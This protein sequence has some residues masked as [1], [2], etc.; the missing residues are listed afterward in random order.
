MPTKRIAGRGEALLSE[1]ARARVVA[2]LVATYGASLTLLTAVPAAVAALD[3]QFALAATLA[4]A[5][6]PPTVAF[7]IARRRPMSDR[8][9]RI[10]ALAAVVLAFVLGALLVAAGFAALGLSP[11]FAFFEAVSAITTTGLSVV[12][13]PEAWPWSAHFLR[14]WVQWL[15]G[16]AFITLALALVVGRGAVALRLGQ[17]DDPGADPTTSMVAR[18]RLMLLA[19]VGVTAASVVACAAA[20]GDPG[21]G[22]PFAL[23]AVSTGGF[24]PAADSLA[25]AAVAAQTAV[26]IAILAGA[27][28]LSIWD[29][30]RRGRG[31]SAARDPEAVVFLSLIAVASLAAAL[32]EARADGASLFDTAFSVASAVSTAGFST[33]AIDALQ[34]AT[35]AILVVVMLIGGCVGSTAGGLKVYRAAFAA[36]ALRL[37]LRRATLSPHAVSHLRVFG[38]RTEPGEGADAFGLLAMYAAMLAVGW[39]AACLAGA[40]PFAAL[41]DTVSALSTV[42]LSLGVYGPDASDGLALVGVAL[43][44][45]GRLEFFA[46]LLVLSPSTWTRSLEA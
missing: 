13:A 19:Y 20:A 3:A 42:G 27:L 15:G 5:S 11:V 32:I 40:A 43:M 29:G 25:S 7:L 44:L 2:H 28:P 6:A 38:R 35:L 36:A 18:A 39:I 22:V 8:P 34:P 17:A 37:T 31:L 21:D 33:T 24:A 26:Y 14:A 45:F 41:F 1:K 9:R 10:E 23:A 16:F 4:A 30:L 46:V 12:G